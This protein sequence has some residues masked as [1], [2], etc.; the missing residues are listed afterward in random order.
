MQRSPSVLSAVGCL[1]LTSAVSLLPACAD[2]PPSAGDDEAVSGKEQA[3][4][5]SA[6]GK[7]LALGR[8][9]GCSLDPG[10]DGIL[11]W[12]DNAHGQTD[13][14][15]LLTNPTFIAAGGDITCAIGLGGAQCWGDNAHRQRN[16]PAT[17]GTPKQLAV[18]NA[19]VCALTGNNGVRC[20][21]DDALGQRKVPRLRDV[22]E[23]SAGANHTCALSQSGV[24]C[25]G[26]NSDGQLDV[27]PL[28]K[29]LHVAAGATHT[30]AIDSTGVVCWG[31]ASSA[32]V[33]DIPE[34]LRPTSIASGAHHSCVLDARG[35]Q[36]WGD[37][38]ASSL[39]PP[40]LSNALQLA[41]GGGD[42]LAHAC[43][44]HLQGV[45]CW[46]DDSLGQTKYEG[47][48]LHVLHHSES[49]IDAPA[50]VIWEVIMDLDSYPDWNP[51]TIAM[52]STLR[53]GD[54]MVMTVKMNELITLEQTENIRI[55]EEGH[56]VCWGIDTTTPAL[57]SGERCQWLEELEGGSTRYIT[58][59]LIEGTLNP[60]VNALFGNDVQVGFD[61]VALALKA[62]AESLKP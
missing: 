45:R 62:R 49:T 58:E 6:V 31:G 21:G 18:G 15:A 43:A 47:G 13:V 52:K 32:V 16:V 33:D 57:N 61:K 59:D 51:Y 35:V 26:D 9:H 24:T 38:E 27:P 30:C 14:P 11:C 10:I 12:G 50:S 5:P 46:G 8:A 53:V 28:V 41:V 34:V 29:P 60:L 39:Y 40:E 7:Q 4:A 36:C 17:L 44:R 3:A 20:W 1:A 55:L 56:K 54:P 42:G 48:D 25:W 19:H 37:P 23:L 2:V 22:L